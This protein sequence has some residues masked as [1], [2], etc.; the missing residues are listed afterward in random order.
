MIIFDTKDSGVINDILYFDD[1]SIKL[2]SNKQIAIISENPKIE[3]SLDSADVFQFFTVDKAKNIISS[4][5][6]TYTSN[7]STT[8]PDGKYI[9][10]INILAV[11]E[12]EDTFIDTIYI[13]DGTGT[14]KEFVLQVTTIDEEDRF[15]V[16]LA[17][18]KFYINDTFLNS[19]RDSDINEHYTD[20]KLL[21]EKRR[22]MLLDLF[23]IK[24]FIGVYYGLINALKY[25]GYDDDVVIKEFWTYFDSNINEYILSRH[26]IE[27]D[28]STLPKGY[29]KTN[30]FNLTYKYNDVS[31]E[32]DENDMPELISSFF[33]DYEALVKMNNLKI[34]LQTYFLPAHAIIVE[35]LGEH[36]S[37]YK[38]GFAYYV[39]Q[40]V[41]HYYDTEV[42]GVYDVTIRKYHEN[43]QVELY[44]IPKTGVIF[45][46]YAVRISKIFD[47]VSNSNVTDLQRFYEDNFAYVKID[48][49]DNFYKYMQSCS[50]TVVDSKDRPVLSIAPEDITD[51]M[52]IGLLRDG[53][54][55]IK[56]ICT[57]KYNLLH[58]YYLDFETEFIKHNFEVFTV[59]NDLNYKE[60]L[61]RSVFDTTKEA[62]EYFKYV[63]EWKEF[64]QKQIEKSYSGLQILHGYDSW[65]PGYGIQNYHQYKD[66]QYPLLQDMLANLKPYRFFTNNM[67]KINN[68]KIDNE[69]Y[70]DIDKELYKS[71][72]KSYIMVTHELHGGENKISGTINGKYHEFIF[73]LDSEHNPMAEQVVI[74]QFYQQKQ[75]PKNK[76]GGFNDF[77]CY[78]YFVTDAQ[79]GFARRYV[80]L[81]SKHFYDIPS[82]EVVFK[83]FEFKNYISH[84]GAFAYMDINTNKIVKTPIEIIANGISYT[85]NLT[86]DIDSTDVLL[87]ELKQLF[88]QYDALYNFE[89]VK[90]DDK[91]VFING[92]KDF[93]INCK[94]IGSVGGSCKTHVV[95]DLI[96]IDAGS[97]IMQYSIVFAKIDET[98]K[99]R[100]YDITWRLYEESGNDRNLIVESTDY[101]FSNIILDRSS[102]TLELEYYEKPNIL[103]GDVESN[104]DFKR[105]ITKRGVF[106]SKN[107]LFN[108]LY[109]QFTESIYEYR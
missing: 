83:S 25:F 89:A 94:D 100:P 97:D 91:T 56:T 62:F 92:D 28:V 45:G 29:T 58:V 30:M 99:S 109:K 74:T 95:N 81:T 73:N 27:T 43:R 33:N 39:H 96:L 69:K 64:N 36:T 67:V 70:H 108:T 98:A 79:T 34:I 52:Y 77:D 41:I 26:N 78:C 61:E 68:F 11:S 54:Y 12:L 22:E 103:N 72:N 31:G 44:D 5:S 1:V 80:N 14:P 88:S 65:A 37:F 2:Y 84:S 18:N 87:M 49:N 15:A 3:L 60:P 63:R 66:G 53:K 6:K 16:A 42:K 102:Y 4:K 17:N 38:S 32:Y 47:S 75:I 24:S 13:T 9:H 19:F 57:D 51:V 40:A 82:T 48:L 55:Q 23:S 20:Y 71:L 107:N 35:V 46:E 104:E 85:R 50:I 76:L 7:S 86:F 59:K 90:L 21:N 105:T 10:F 106:L 8:G 101:F 93:I